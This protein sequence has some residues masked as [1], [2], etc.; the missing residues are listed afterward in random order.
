MTREYVLGFDVGGTRIKAGAFDR[1]GRTLWSAVMP[2]HAMRGPESLLKSLAA[3]ARAARRALRA[4]P[5]G[6]GLG[7]TGGVDPD[8]GVV[9]LPGKFKD[10]ENFPL[11]PRLREALDVPVFA[12]NDGRLAMMAERRWGLAR[13]VNWAVAITLGTG[14]GSGVL[15]DGRIL[16]DPHRLFGLQI[17]HLVLQNYGGK[18][19]LTG[20]KGTAETLCSAT[21]LA[22]SV[23]D[24]IQR[25]IPS[26]LAG[27]YWNDPHSVDFAAAVRGVARRDPLCVEEFGR[28]V[29]NVGWLLVNAI[30]AYSPELIIL[31]GGATHAA[32]HFL[33]P[34][35]R[36][37][38][39]FT[40]R[41]PPKRSTPV[42]VSKLGDRA[43]VMGAAA[44]MWEAIS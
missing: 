1:A 29:Q 11:V 5:V 2:S 18:L 42:K 35:Q 27:A 30:H 40:F 23:R 25:G 43:G 17:G 33:R 24:G 12:D 44:M 22:M 13:G 31:S 36:H 3:Q 38:D 8:L 39:R 34:L 4:K 7:L 16:R 6:I 41:Y 32:R 20:A 26:M 19:C 15:L 21:A 10:L 14:V 9:H 37:V 28:W